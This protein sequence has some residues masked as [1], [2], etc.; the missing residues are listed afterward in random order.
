MLIYLRYK[1]KYLR[2]DLYNIEDIKY[3][4]KAIRYLTS[5]RLDKEIRRVTIKIV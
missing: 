3:I 1:K 4:T 2:L 5:S